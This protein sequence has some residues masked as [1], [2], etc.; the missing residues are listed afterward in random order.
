MIPIKDLSGKTM[1]VPTIGETIDLQYMQNNVGTV[2][3]MFES[4]ADRDHAIRFAESMI[5]AYIDKVETNTIKR[6]SEIDFEGQCTALLASSIKPKI[7]GLR[8]A[9]KNGPASYGSIDANCLG[10]GQEHDF[11][12]DADNF[13]SVIS[14]RL[15]ER[16]DLNEIDGGLGIYVFTNKKGV[17]QTLVHPVTIFRCSGELECDVF[18]TREAG[19]EYRRPLLDFYRKN[20]EPDAPEDFVYPISDIMQMLVYGLQGFLFKMPRT[21]NGCISIPP[22]IFKD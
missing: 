7:E 9:L 6:L 3:K 21:H 5:D 18:G 12:F 10:I 17:L 8:Y 14:P 4:C 13:I 1:Q 16:N 15:S 20:Y 11:I 22:V 19:E 2:R